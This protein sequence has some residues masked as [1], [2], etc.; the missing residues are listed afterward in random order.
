MP[1][2]ARSVMSMREEF[3]FLAC[4]PGANV[5]ELCRRFRISPT[6]G[7]KWLGRHD[8]AFGEQSLSDRSRR[9]K[10]SPKRS[11][12]RVEAEVL[13]LRQ[14]HPKWGG[15]KLAR[16]M[17]EEE[18][19]GVPSPSTITEILRRHEL[20]DGPRAGQPRQ[21]QRFESPA[22]NDL[23][24]LDFK[25]HFA[26]EAGRCHP[27]T[28]LD[29]HSRYNVVLQA[30]ADERSRTVWDALQASFRLYGLPRR[31]LCD[32]G[33]P[34]GDS[35]RHSFSPLTIRLVQLGISVIHGRP[36]HPQTQGKLERFHRSLKAEAIGRQLLRDNADCQ[37]VFN[38]WR[39]VYN[40]KRPHDALGLATPA[41]RYCA[42]PR[43]LP[44]RIEEYDYGPDAIVRRVQHS[45][46]ITY[47]GRTM[48][49]PKAFHGHRVALRPTMD[50]GV[51]DVFFCHQRIFPLDLRRQDL[52]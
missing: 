12:V 20:L 18:F 40:H 33:P 24:Q 10:H 31:I 30:C 37:Q 3:V 23:W 9:P 21:W 45:G 15:R 32:N 49:L 2:E 13:K 50:D 36:Y 52:D 19:D 1:W 41:S 16:R 6:T 22:A 8:A 4:R 39:E 47:G 28:A 34:W 42:S 38:A 29:D 27:L 5:R 17:L 46:R 25:G 51:F 14:D 35:V 26:T 43:P 11:P 7:Y 48:K 44:E